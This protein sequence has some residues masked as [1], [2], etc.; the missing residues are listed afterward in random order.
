L[1]ELFL[2]GAAFLLLDQ[3]SKSAVRLLAPDQVIYCL[4]FTSIRYKAN[5]NR[6]YR[7]RAVQIAMVAT[8]LW[9]LVSVVVLRRSGGWFQGH[10]P[11]VG[12]GLALGGAAGNLLDILRHQTVVDFID[13]GWWP[14][15]N[16]ADAGIVAGLLL[17]FRY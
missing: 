9:A 6:I 11:L 14:V 7:S 16:L 4:R 10:I 13:L 12:L 1:I 5:A 15:F 17:A 8:W 3:W 2:S